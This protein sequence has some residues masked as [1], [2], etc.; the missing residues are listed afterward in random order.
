MSK[1]SISCRMMWGRLVLLFLFCIA[2]GITGCTEKPDSPPSPPSPASPAATDSI[3]PVTPAPPEPAA[4]PEPAPVPEESQTP[5]TEPEAEPGQDEPEPATPDM[6]EQQPPAKDPEPKLDFG[7]P[8]IDGL[9]KNERLLPNQPIWLTKD[10][11]SV[12]IQTMVCQNKAPLEMFA[13]LLN[14]KEHESV[15]AVPVKAAYVHTGLLAA[16]A[17]EGSPVTW[18]PEYKPPTGTEIDIT[19]LWKDEQGKVQKAR[20]QDWVQD[21]T[22][23]KA[24]AH[25]WVFAGSQM[26]KDE[27]TGKE[28]YLADLT[29][30]LIC[31]SNFPS[32]TLDV[33]IKSSDSNAALMFEAFTKNIPPLGTPVTMVL[34][35]MTAEKKPSETPPKSE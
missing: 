35:P 31:V 14:S 23:G 6:A 3:A 28:Q 27:D 32:A 29:G 21:M 25:P 1:K 17:K 33:P 34:T 4:E 19:V 16:G 2:I 20:A 10:G 9:G 15:L 13:C 8:L 18:D 11:K 12:V 24:M 30:E 22:T 26:I 5:A 7:E